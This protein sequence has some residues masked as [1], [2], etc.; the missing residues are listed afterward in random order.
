MTNRIELNVI[1]IEMVEDKQCPGCIRGSNTKCGSFEMHKDEEFFTCKNWRPSTFMSGVGRIVL[2]MPRGFN[3]TGCVEF[4]DKPFVYM[5]LYESPE[6]M[7][8]Y[9]KFNVAVWAMEHDGYLYVRC[10]SP[11]ANHLYVDVIK[12][13]KMEN[14]PGAV[15]VGEFYNEID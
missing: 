13:G 5:R 2:G 6:K 7:M 4:G 15:N 8:N 11:R 14:V 1:Q 3:R 10:Y 12:G 9:N